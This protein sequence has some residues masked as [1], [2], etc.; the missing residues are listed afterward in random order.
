[1]IKRIK[2]VEGVFI[3]ETAFVCGDVEIGEDSS[4]W[5]GAVLRG[6]EDSITIGRRTNIQDNCVIHCDKG[7]PVKIGN[8]VTVGHGCVIHGCEIGDGSLIGMGAVVLNGAKIGKNCLIGAGAVV[9][10]KTDAPDGSMLLGSPAKVK[11]EL[12]SHEISANRRSAETY[13]ERA[14]EYI[15]NS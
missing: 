5:F 1:M 4:I 11:R 15:E 12:T 9:T 3:A 14:K 7:L 6:D 13:V 8:E 10:G 2:K